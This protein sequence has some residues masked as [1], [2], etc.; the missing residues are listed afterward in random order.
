MRR[1]RG[2]L[3]L[4]T[5][6]VAFAVG[7][8]W[9]PSQATA[10][11]ATA[12]TAQSPIPRPHATQAAT[13][14]AKGRHPKHGPKPAE[15]V[16]PVRASGPGVQIVAAP[17]GLSIEYPTMAADLGAGPCPPPALVSALQALGSPPLQLAGDSQDLTAPPGT[18]SG[19]QASW[20]MATLYQLPAAFWS[21]LH[22]LLNT[23]HE[24][25]TV[26]LNAKTGQPGW[27]VQMVT[28]AQGAATNGLSFS[29]GNEP[30]LYYLPNYSSLSR[31]VADEESAAVNAYLQVAATLRQA[32]GTAPIVG[33]ELALPAR[34]RSE[35]PRVIGS[36]PAQTV[37]V[38]LYPLSACTTP[39]AVTI[40]G[41]LSDEAAEAPRRLAWVVADAREA[42]VP[43]IL[44]EANSASC[45]GVAGVS[46]SP[47]SGVWA[48]RFLLNALL[49]GFQEVR[50]HLS[51]APYDPFA[52]SGEQVLE[53]PLG[54]ALTTLS[55]WLPV[56]ATLRTLPGVEGLS[57]TSVTAPAGAP[58]ASTPP[59]QPTSSPA[60][61]I[62][63]A[64]G[65]TTVILDNESPRA[66]AV[67]VRGAQAVHIQ[68]LT[69]TRAGVLG[70]DLVSPKSRIALTVPA[71]GVVTVSATP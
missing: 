41:M 54:A 48:V 37:G 1:G 68:T 17:V 24:P 13:T 64:P 28:G 30:D 18:L 42:G 63:P 70:A 19:Q 61:P 45:G 12:R 34:W 71:N 52:I 8:A 26:G 35:L 32:V 60:P 55:Q 11:Q 53:R 23:T 31:P 67:L 59:G 33:P 50:F 15:V 2:T 20:E 14:A 29:L 22:C 56:G 62:T 3:A 40:G 57:A 4:R 16:L 44:S 69:P 7:L 58:G 38:H 46:D 47:A 43:A 49:T 25:L 36:L 65:T 9:T 27:A 51:G 6:T 66:R 5:L 21:Q 39:K 10:A